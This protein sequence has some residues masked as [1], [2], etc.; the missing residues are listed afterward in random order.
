MAQKRDQ[1]GLV[2]D[3]DRRDFFRLAAAGLAL[4]GLADV[5]VS[6]TRAG[7]SG[8]T[9]PGA[10]LP[11]PANAVTWPIF[12][13]NSAIG[14]GLLI[15]RG[16]TLKVYEWR[17]YLA[18]LV[19]QSFEERYRTHDVHVDVS[20][21]ENRDA[22]AARIAQ[23]GSDLDVFFPTVDQLG[24]L[25]GAKLL[26]PLNHD[27][28]P[29]LPGLWPAFGAPTAPF[30]DVGQGY[31]VPYTVFS[32]GVG[33]RRDLVRAQE[34][35]G[36]LDDPCSIFGNS[37]YR[38]KIGVL[39]AYRE[40]LA[41][42]LQDRGH[43]D[44]NTGDGTE[45]SRAADELI[46]FARA[47]RLKATE[48]G[49]YEGLARGEFA[50]HQAWSGDVLAARRF[51]GASGALTD[52]RLG[53][54]WMRDGGV[55]GCDLLAVLSTG[56]NPVLAHLFLNHL[57]DLDVAMRNFA[58]N[59]YQP[60]LVSA[61]REAF[62]SAEWGRAVPPHLLESTILTPEEFAAGSMLLRLDPVADARW[63]EQWRRFTSAA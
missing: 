45:L 29:N 62:A 55:V 50:V 11:R 52:E 26:R 3:L 19:I 18:P 53:Y 25:I 5:L 10:S 39:D 46:G 60:P 6:C 48:D 63:I 43:P 14:S 31:T 44:V 49:D 36:E 37:R 33:Y 42:A 24:D 35:P 28:L 13:D 51:G 54:W 7:E 23:P 17:E 58:W 2:R 30:Y 15:E 27:Y 32:T 4:P 41:M 12:E 16:A 20:S 9:R 59:G 8:V 1:D 34:A 61:T 47:T 38:G 56:R 22:A 57:L 21:F 40:P